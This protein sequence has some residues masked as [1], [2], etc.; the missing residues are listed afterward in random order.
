[1]NPTL[2]SVLAAVLVVLLILAL[3]SLALHLAFFLIGLFFFLAIIAA[4]TWV[5]GTVWRETQRR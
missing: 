5:V 2:R 1:M 4:I 3:G